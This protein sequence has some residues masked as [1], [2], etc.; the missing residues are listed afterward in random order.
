MKNDRKETFIHY[1]ESQNDWCT[2]KSLASYFKVSTRTIRKYVN[3]I[4]Q[5]QT[6]IYSSPQGYHLVERANNKMD[7]DTASPTKRLNIILK[8]LILSSE[9]INIF[10][11][12]DRLFLS[13]SSIENDI[14]HANKLIE[15]YQLK[16]RHKKDTL[17]LIGEE[18]YKRK[19]MSYIISQ[20]TSSEFL[21]IKTVQDSFSEYDVSWIKSKIISILEKYNLYVNDYIM[22]NI[23]LHLIITV[24]RIKN[25]NSVMHSADLHKVKSNLETQAA[26]KIASFLEG[27]YNI[28][29][30]ESEKYDFILLLSSKTTLLNYQTLT[31]SSLYQYV[32]EHYVN[33][34]K[35]LLEKVYEQYFID[36]SDDEFFVKFTLHIRNL[37]FR[38]K[39]EKMT[40]NPLT[41]KIKDSYPLIYE[42][43]VFVSNQLQILEKIHIKEDEISFIAFHIGSFFERKKELEKKILC[44][45]LC[46][47]YYD[48]QLTLVQKLEKKYQ[49]SIEI[50]QVCTEISEV[51]IHQKVDLF[52]STLPIKNKEVPSVI[53]HPYL[54]EEDHEYIQNQV[55]KLKRQKEM[56]KVKKYLDLYFNKDLFMKNVY[57]DNDEQ[58][59]EY[60]SNLLYEKGYVSKEYGQSILEREKMSST[61][62]NNNVAVPHSMGMDAIKT[63]ICMII[64]DRPV[65][66]GKEK[67][68][69]I[70]MISIN[71]QNRELFSPFFEGVINVLSE[72]KNTNELI[73]AIDYE[74]FMFKMSKLFS[75]Q[76]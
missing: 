55:T 14:V 40:K 60:M 76:A 70:A 65:K 7:E 56:S 3:E 58:Y 41:H 4:N 68:Q 62:F 23:L 51:K 63:G 37:I 45:I 46:P 30:N 15:T 32:N 11:L 28:H 49:E 73:Q 31:P 24:D 6:V 47:N 16:I 66:W 61:A 26:N 42:L 59:I 1:L 53:V 71:N 5:N 19:L 21:S 10:D 64:L 36:I 54:T 20:E 35:R 2:A 69:I 74:D 38:V 48:M 8:E 27:T 9:G 29:F 67:V 72:W 50:I 34:T 43:A 39:N 44:V 33:L 57:L 52:I 13:I 22:N 75:I 17:L 25:N 12:S 18:R